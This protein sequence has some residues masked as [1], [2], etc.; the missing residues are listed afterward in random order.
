[1]ATVE[2]VQVSVN[3]RQ[4]SANDIVAG[5]CKRVYHVDIDHVADELSPSRRQAPRRPA[6]DRHVVAVWGL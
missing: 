6:G 3:R 2:S 4:S 1:V 5:T